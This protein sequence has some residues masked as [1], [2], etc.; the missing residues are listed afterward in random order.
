[1]SASRPKLLV[2]D[3]EPQILEGLSR[4]LRAGF[5]VRTATSGAIGLEI[6]AREPDVAIVMSDM[7]MPVMNG[8][9]FL[10]RAREVA[11]NAVRLLLTGQA[12]MEDAI[13]AINEGAIFRFLKKPCALD[14]MRATLGDAADQHRLI[15]AERQLLEQTLHGAVKALCDTLALANPSVFGMAM[16]V[17]RLAARIAAKVGGTELWQVEVAAMLCQLGAMTVPAGIYERRALGEPLVPSEREMLDRVPLVT[18]QLLAPIPRLEPV[19]E[20]VLHSRSGF[21][22]SGAPENQPR[23]GFEIPRGARVLK[24]A[25]DF[26]ELESAGLAP[27]KAIERM[28]AQAELYDPVI[29]DALV[30]LY[31]AADTTVIEIPISRLLEGMIIATD[32]ITRNGTLLVARGHEVT[33]GLVRRLENFAASIDQET[34][35]IMADAK[36]QPLRRNAA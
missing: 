21:D 17:K 35:E 6:L 3:D 8:T 22:L 9:V 20:I 5:D 23:T 34:V 33:L 36:L 16:R 4:G 18:D 19:R 24:V 7:R 10:S 15:I 11:P 28:R 2:V 32:V 12:D 31:V 25:L 14:V 30:E 13:G 26:E 1:M 27:D 29:L